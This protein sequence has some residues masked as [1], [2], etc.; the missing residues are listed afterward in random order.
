[1]KITFLKNKIELNRVKDYI[2]ICQQKV[3]LICAEAHLIMHPETRGFEKF[4]F[5]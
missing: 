5:K 3:H 4:S 2:I 1:M